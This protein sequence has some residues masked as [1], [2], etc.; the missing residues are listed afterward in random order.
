MVAIAVTFL[1]GMK[2][3]VVDDISV[4]PIYVRMLS[5]VGVLA[6]TSLVLLGIWPSLYTI[7]AV[8]VVPA[9]F[10]FVLNL[11]AKPHLEMA[12]DASLLDSLCRD[13][14]ICMGNRF[15]LAIYALSLLNQ[16][17]HG[18][19]LAQLICRPIRN[20]EIK[21]KSTLPAAFTRLRPTDLFLTSSA[22]SG[23][24]RRR[25]CDIIYGNFR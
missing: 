15:Y 19:S 22:G 23:N 10:A 21:W 5:F 2:I 13:F 24:F 3:V 1:V 7:L 25:G 18:L 14:S 16:L 20:Q 8:P 9:P 17:V 4:N 6:T 12:Q 11:P